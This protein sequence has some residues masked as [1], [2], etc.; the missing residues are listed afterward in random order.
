M[1]SSSRSFHLCLSTILTS[2]PW[3]FILLN[4]VIQPGELLL[5]QS[6]EIC[7]PTRTLTTTFAMSLLNSIPLYQKKNNNSNLQFSL[8]LCFSN[9]L[10]LFWKN[11]HSVII[12]TIDIKSIE[13]R[14][15]V[16]KRLQ[17]THKQTVVS[18]WNLAALT[19]RYLNWHLTLTHSKKLFLTMVSPQISLGLHLVS[20]HN[21]SA[22]LYYSA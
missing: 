15:M 19:S 14:L 22:C 4:L 1:T 18:F 16:L 17:I 2:K 3:T 21:G 12:L 10:S 13:P 9:H 20:P 11:L 5:G 6:Q 7:N 8:L